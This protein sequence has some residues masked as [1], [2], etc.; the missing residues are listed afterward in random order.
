MFEEPVQQRAR[1]RAEEAKRRADELRRRY[2]EL[3]E[4]PGV[5]L[6]QLRAAAEAAGAA[7]G[8]AVAAHRALLEQFERSAAAHDDAADAH[9]R[10]AAPQHRHAAEMH[11]AA[12]HQD[13]TVAAQLRGPSGRSPLRVSRSAVRD[14]CVLTVDGALDDTSYSLLRDS[15]VK[16]ALDEPRAVIVDITGLVVRHDPAWAVFTSARWEVT[17]WPDTPI[18]LVCTHDQGRNALQHNGIIR[19]VPVY[20]SL[21]SAISDLST[22]TPRRYRQRARAS[23][24]A[25]KT[26]S[27]R[28]R[29][30]AVQ[31]LT[32]WSRTDF[33][34]AVSIVAT[35][36]VEIALTNTDSEISLRL[37]SDGCTVAV[38]VQ[39][40]GPAPPTGRHSTGGN[41]GGLD[42]VAAT[43][44]VWGGY[45]TATGNTLWAALG[46]ENR[47]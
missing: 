47:F 45:T 43:S 21:Q 12:A 6:K 22:E 46:P 34:H 16:A 31:W 15:I 23:L 9:D 28:C 2:V 39:Y 24:P 27:Q 8:N 4:S 32:A 42:L 40:L 5:S 10:A 44:R 25:M 19:Y 37:E 13:R 33:I 36:L 38:A 35:E 11:R 26:S 18:G 7:I 41:I 3:T 14:I 17:E 20:P 1:R 29:Q 30:L